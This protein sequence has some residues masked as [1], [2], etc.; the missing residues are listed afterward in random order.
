MNDP[1]NLKDNKKSAP[2]RLALQRFSKKTSLYQN[3]QN[4]DR[5]ISTP[6]NP[7]LFNIPPVTLSLLVLFAAIYSCMSFLIPPGAAYWAYIHLGFIPGR[8]TGN[9]LFNPIQFITPFTH[10]FLHGSWLHLGM[11]SLMLLA[12][13]SGLEK[14]IGARR[15][16]LI[17]I[18]S[19]LFGILAHFLLFPTA[20]APVVG[21][22]GGLS[23]LF[24]AVLVTMNRQSGNKNGL[25]AFI[26]LWIVISVVFGMTGGPD[27]MAIAWAAHIGG[28]LGGLALVRFLKI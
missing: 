7:P 5:D 16:I 25:L 20:I 9:A 4:V 13:G 10:M 27:N 3:R 24:A 18:A 21:A 17:F 14:W 23:G 8:F 12:F 22:S 2:R 26:V 15:M 1:D 6:A 11:N 28:F 19:G